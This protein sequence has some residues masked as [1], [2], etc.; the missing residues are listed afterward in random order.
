MPV[1]KLWVNHVSMTG[2]PSAHVSYLTNGHQLDADEQACVWTKSIPKACK[3]DHHALETHWAGIYKI[4]LEERQN[5][6]GMVRHNARVTAR[7]F[8]IN[9]PNDLSADHIH[10]LA[11]AVLHDFPRHL[12]V[13][14][15]L[16]RSSNRGKEHLHL[17]GLFSYRNGGYGAIQEQFRL[18]ITKQM[19]ATVTRELTKAGYTVDVGTPCGI[20]ASERRWLNARGTVEERRN[21]R[22]MMI[23]SAIANSPQL[24]EYCK[25]QAERMLA[26]MRTTSSVNE[27]MNTYDSMDQLLA[28]YQIKDDIRL[29]E[30]HPAGGSSAGHAPLTQQILEQEL[31]KARRWNRSTRITKSI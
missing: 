26:R 7:Q 28:T 11:K 3:T 19:K 27:V 5:P 8:V 14:M 12:P 2:D 24:K 17:Q 20:S 1:A 6:D 10:S 22:F 9:L 25:R 4:F 16:H 29:Q 23:L 18:N 31:R 13:S 30:D 15:V 21:P